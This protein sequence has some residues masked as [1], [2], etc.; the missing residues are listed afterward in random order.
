MW[1]QD[2][3]H[4][5]FALTITIQDTELKLQSLINIHQNVQFFVSGMCIN[6]NPSEDIDHN[7]LLG[8]V[9]IHYKVLLW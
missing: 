1:E 9:C 3:K 4:S 7:V 5:L 2:H 6:L 8:T